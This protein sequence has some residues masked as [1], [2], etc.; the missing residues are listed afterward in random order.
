MLGLFDYKY[1][2]KTIAWISLFY[3]FV[4]LN[5]SLKDWFILLF[6]FLNH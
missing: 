3:F 6:I 5:T 4:E 1:L 2:H